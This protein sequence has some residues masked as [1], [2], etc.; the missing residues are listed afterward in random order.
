MNLYLL[1]RTNNIG[2]EECESCVVVS[3]TTKKALKIHPFFSNI[4][5]A[6][7]EKQRS[8]Y[9]FYSWASPDNIVVTYIGLA[10]PALEEGGV[11]CASYNAG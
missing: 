4:K 3:S 5:S 7:E 10:A 11:I 6:L 8:S 2:I 1:T 9:A